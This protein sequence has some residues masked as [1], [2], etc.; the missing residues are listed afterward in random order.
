MSPV[1]AIDVVPQFSD[2]RAAHVPEKSCTRTL[3]E[4]TEL[5]DMVGFVD[6]ATKAYQTSSN[7][8]PQPKVGMVV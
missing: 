5:N 4:L 1:A 8:P 7:A 2:V 3:V 6:L